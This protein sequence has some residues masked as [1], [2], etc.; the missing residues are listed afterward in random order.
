MSEKGNP[1]EN[2]LFTG[3]SSGFGLETA[4]HFLGR[5]WN[6]VATMRTPREDILPPSERLRAL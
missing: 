3:C 6:V 5:G 1:N 2:L 4:R